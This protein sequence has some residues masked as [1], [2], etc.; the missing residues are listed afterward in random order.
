[1]AE[2]VREG[3]AE[4]GIG[5]LKRLPFKRIASAGRFD[6]NDATA[7]GAQPFERG[8]VDH[9]RARQA[10]A[11]NVLPAKHRKASVVRCDM[12]G[13]RR[14]RDNIG[15]FAKAIA[16]ED[17]NRAFAVIVAG[18]SP[19]EARRVFIENDLRRRERHR[20]EVGIVREGFD[21]DALR[22]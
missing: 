16:R 20:E 9:K 8:R 10:R 19:V 4:V 14:P 18:L 13:A 17:A 6:D 3:L 7:T 15:D 22:Q 2:L 11:E 1:M 12:P 21:R 5:H